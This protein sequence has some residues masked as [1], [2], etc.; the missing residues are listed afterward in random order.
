[1]VYVVFHWDECVDLLGGDVNE[2]CV[3]A[4]LAKR[5]VVRSFVLFTWRGLEVAPPP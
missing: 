5:R 2:A 4:E 3:S 1:M